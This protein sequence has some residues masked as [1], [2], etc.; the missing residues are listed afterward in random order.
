MNNTGHWTEVLPLDE[1][2]KSYQPARSVAPDGANTQSVTD[3]LG[4]T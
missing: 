1:N 3:H 4:L 2:G